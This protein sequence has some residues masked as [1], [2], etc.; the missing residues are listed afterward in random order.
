MRAQYK[1]KRKGSYRVESKNPC[2]LFYN[3]IFCLKKII[4]IDPIV[5]FYTF[6][7]LVES[8]IPAA[9]RVICTFLFDFF[10]FL[11]KLKWYAAY[12]RINGSIIFS[13]LLSIFNFSSLVLW[14]V[15]PWEW[16]GAGQVLGVAE[17]SSGRNHATSTKN[18]NYLRRFY[19]FQLYHKL[20]RKVP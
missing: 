18:R 11:W 1:P 20:H 5:I 14:M 7:G 6:R 13:F 9:F 12:L 15:S 17:T 10:L 2:S 3:D 8:E 19:T 16:G 4:S